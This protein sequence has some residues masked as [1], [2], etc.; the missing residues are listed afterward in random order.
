M[1]LIVLA[2]ALFFGELLVAGF[3]V[4][5][6]GAVI[7]LILGGLLL[8]S[9]SNPDFQVSRWLIYGLAGIIGVF[10]LMVVNA[11]LRSRR[12]PAVTGAQALVG[13]SAVARSALDPEGIVF[14]EGE[15]WRARAE[16][17]AVRE[18]ESVT[19]VD[20]R[21][22]RLRVRKAANEKAADKGG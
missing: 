4:L 5:G 22:L 7:S 21:G 11:I 18:G 3:G 12:M 15:R 13:R 6:I 17:E 20:V 14:L 2:F 1:L 19:I 8:T 16:D 10:F 9:T